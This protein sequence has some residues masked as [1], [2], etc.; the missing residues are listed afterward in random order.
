MYR[1]CENLNKL[2]HEIIKGNTYR[3]DSFNHLYCFIYNLLFAYACVVYSLFHTHILYIH[4]KTVW[5]DSRVIGQKVLMANPNKQDIHQNNEAHSIQSH[6]P[7]LE[8][9]IPIVS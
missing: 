3:F 7:T 9:N 8:W 6:H 5:Y 1:L 4:F 2:I